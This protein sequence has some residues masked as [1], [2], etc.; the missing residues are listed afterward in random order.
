MSADDALM[1]CANE[2]RQHDADR[3]LVTTL[4]PPPAR[5]IALALFALDLELARI[6]EAVSE[7]ALGEMRLQFWRD[8]LTRLSEGSVAAHP[9][10]QGIADALGEDVPLPTLLALVD[11]RGRDL[12]DEPPKNM[13]ELVQYGAGTAGA[14]NVLLLMFLGV[15]D[16]AVAQAAR[17]AGTGWRLVGLM[18]DLPRV[19]A[20]RRLPI[21]EDVLSQ[22]A[23]DREAAFAGHF[24]PELGKAVRAVVAEAETHLIEARQ[25]HLPKP[26]RPIFATVLL[27]VRDAKALQK[28]NG[29]PFGLKPPGPLSRQLTMALS[30][31]TG[32]KG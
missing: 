30:V 27:A 29:N 17:A 3:Y 32:K 22:L 8:T 20:R 12:D 1:H 9:V 26:A 14:L 23:V 28:A 24:T 13:G 5:R 16:P 18:R 11:A 4:L 19:L 15:K 31:L 10:A 25:T 21:P 7:R 2:L 6:P